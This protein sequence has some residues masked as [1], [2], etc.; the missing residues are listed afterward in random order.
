MP[1]L[2]KIET[3][4]TTP[5]ALEE[6][7]RRA[8]DAVEKSNDLLL[9]EALATSSVQCNNL[10]SAQN[11]LVEGL[12]FQV[13]KVKESNEWH[14]AQLESKTNKAVQEIRQIAQEERKFKSEVSQEIRTAI[15]GTAD[16]VTAYAKSQMDKST[17]HIKRELAECA[18]ELAKQRED[19]KE[20]GLI[21]KIFFWATPAFLLLQ[22]VLLAFA[23][24]G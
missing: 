6:L 8:Q 2:Q 3:E 4:E 20:Q 7:S 18:R 21:R 17:E 15:R 5:T 12:I 11:S 10:I 14:E 24:F 13:E 1:R 9:R 22:T 19:M 23:L 16:E